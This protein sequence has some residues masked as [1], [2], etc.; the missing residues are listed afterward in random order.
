M[1]LYRGMGDSVNWKGDQT[2]PYARQGQTDLWALILEFEP[3]ARLDYRL[4]IN[5]GEA[6]LDPLNPLTQAGGLGANSVVHMPRH[7]YPEFTLPREDVPNGSLSD[8]MLITSRHLGYDV[9]YRVHT[10]AGYETMENLPTV[11]V[12]DGQDY[13]N[14]EFGALTIVLDNLIADGKIKPLIAVLIDPRDPVSGENRRQVELVPASPDQCTFCDFL[15]GELVP[16]IDSKYKTD[17]VP[18]SRAVIGFSLGG[19]F[20]SQMGLM[21]P[22]VFHLIGIQSPYFLGHEWIFEGYGRE[23]QPPVKIFLS[24][25]SYDQGADS[26]RLRDLLEKE[27]YALLYVETHDGHSWGNIRGLLDDMLIYF[28][29]S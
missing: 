23:N 27:G 10:P 24:H 11:Y 22:D 20:T 15:A 28:F 14:P 25:G 2:L 6:I 21:Y 7:V 8:N 17:A 16:A 1:F 3:D 26:L 4:E 13:S 19:Q 12:T 29:G 5:N 18:D 9:N